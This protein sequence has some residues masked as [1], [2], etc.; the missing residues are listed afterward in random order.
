MNCEA[1]ADF[2][3]RQ[4]AFVRKCDDGS[5]RFAVF[6]DIES[7]QAAG[8]GEVSACG[9]ITVT[10]NGDFTFALDGDFEDK[11][12]TGFGGKHCFSVK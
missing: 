1:G 11:R 5:E 3:E 6:G 7:A 12:I 9:S 8:Q 2:T 10:A 4:T